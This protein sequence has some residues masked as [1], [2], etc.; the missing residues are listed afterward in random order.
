MKLKTAIPS[1][2]AALLAAAPFASAQNATTDPVGFVNY[3]VRAVSDQNLGVPML[4]A[5]LYTGVATAV[6]ATQVSAANVPAISSTSYLVVTSG[7]AQGLWEAVSSSTNSTI[8]LAS[9]ITGFSANHSFTVRPFWTL[10]TLFPNGGG[11]PATADVFNPT[12]LVFTYDPSR[13]GINLSSA[14]QYM[15]HSGS[16]DYPA[17]WYDAGDPDGGLKNNLAISPETYITVRNPTSSNVTLSFVGSVPTTKFALDVVSRLAG[18][19]DNLVFNKF[20]ADVTLGASDLA[21]SGAVAPTT[22]VFNPGDLLLVF[23]F[24]NSGINPSSSSQY[25]YHSGS[26]DYPA[27]WY[28]AGDPDGGIKNGVVIPAGSSLVIRKVAGTS[29]A[30]SWN[31]STPYSVQ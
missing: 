31:P 3:T 24:N 10:S 4:P 8:T 7:P 30:V 1:I 17:G 12:G 28:D 21:S 19:Q 6:S 16:P 11:V 15:Y 25:M 2:A 26:P 5:A 29:S 23:N 9:A 27:G 20:P 13:T 22:D 14:N 18:P